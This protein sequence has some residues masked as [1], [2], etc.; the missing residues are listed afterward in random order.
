MEAAGGRVS[1][2]G[3]FWLIAGY[4]FLYI[5]IL[6]LIIY[7]FNDSKMV[8]LWGGFTFKWYGVLAEDKEALDAPARIGSSASHAS[9]ASA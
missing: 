6:T 5:P 3:R 9:A 1:N 8:T 4:A 7:S 2:F